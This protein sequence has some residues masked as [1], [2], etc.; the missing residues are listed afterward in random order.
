MCVCGIY[1]ERVCVCASKFCS[2]KNSDN[3]NKKNTKMN[4]YYLGV[5]ITT[6]LKT[7]PGWR[8]TSLVP[9]EAVPS[10]AMNNVRPE[11]S[12]VDCSSW[13]S[14][15]VLK[16]SSTN[17]LALTRV[18][19][20]RSDTVGMGLVSVACFRRSAARFMR[21]NEPVSTVVKAPPV[22]PGA[23]AVGLLSELCREC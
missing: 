9:K 12:C 20:T 23:A 17:S 21:S 11:V 5:C 14:F 15:E 6:C 22:L 4:I 10:F 16:I 18:H 2:C 19:S 13:S 3:H 8:L 7:P 1:K